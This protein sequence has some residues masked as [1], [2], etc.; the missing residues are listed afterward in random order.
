MRTRWSEVSPEYRKEL[1]HLHLSADQAL[2]LV[3]SWTLSQSR[4]GHCTPGLGRG[5]ESGYLCSEAETWF[6][7]HLAQRRQMNWRGW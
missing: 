3:T 1:N 4:G 2:E 6:C 7:A 5:L